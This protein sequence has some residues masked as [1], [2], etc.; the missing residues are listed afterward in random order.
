MGLKRRTGS[1]ALLRSEGGLKRCSC[2]EV[3]ECDANPACN[4]SPTHEFHWRWDHGPIEVLFDRHIDCCC[5]DAL[6]YRIIYQRMW[7]ASA[8]GTGNDSPATSIRA[9]AER[10][11]WRNICRMEPEMVGRRG[12]SM[13]GLGLSR[14][15]LHYR[16]HPP[17]HRGMNAHPP[18]AHK[19]PARL[20]SALAHG[21][22]AR[23][24]R[25]PWSGRG[26]TQQS[27]PI[28]DPD[29]RPACACASEPPSHE[30]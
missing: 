11:I 10:A 19:R 22:S 17:I 27:P 20:P 7:R 9:G 3:C 2:C 1:G 23:P 21:C 12:D 5:N 29:Q 26:W 24:H 15:L 4:P 28:H 8:D 14:G 16:V 18:S 13:A 30:G 25:R 6:A